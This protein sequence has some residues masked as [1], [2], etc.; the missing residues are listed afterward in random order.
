M[1]LGDTRPPTQERCALLPG[2]P[3]PGHLQSTV[4]P[5]TRPANQRCVRPGH[6]SGVSVSRVN[7]GIL[8]DD[9]IQAPP[10]T[11]QDHIS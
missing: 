7:V 8:P 6:A 5:R 9:L 10:D 11:H 4:T 1:G 2:S 3:A